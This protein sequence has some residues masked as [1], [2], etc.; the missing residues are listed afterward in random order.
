MGWLVDRIGPHLVIGMGGVT[1]CIGAET[2]AHT[3]AQDS[4]GMFVGLMLVGLGWSFGLIAGSAMLTGAFPVA[5][6]VEVQGGAD[7]IMTTS[8]A[9]AGLGAGAA[10]EAVGFHLLSH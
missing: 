10:V 9:V 6:R 2:A 4:L 5:Q 1:L 8:G 7:F 3:S